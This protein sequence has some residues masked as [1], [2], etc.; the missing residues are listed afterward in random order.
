MPTLLFGTIGAPEIAIV[1]GVIVLMFG[2]GKISGLGR[3]FGNSIKEFR[4]AVKE[5]IDAES[6]DSPVEDQ[7]QTA[8][9]VK[10][11]QETPPSTAADSSET[12]KNIF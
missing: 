4:R 9:S 2:V 5:P 8:A 3:E 10:Q 11:T 7:P 1:A 12:K 6:D